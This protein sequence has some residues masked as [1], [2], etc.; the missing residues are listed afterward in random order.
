MELLTVVLLI[1]LGLAAF[2]GA[3]LAWG[4]DSRDALPDDHHR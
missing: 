4:S 2:D 1:V 3:A